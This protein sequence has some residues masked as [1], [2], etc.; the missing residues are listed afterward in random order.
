MHKHI[1]SFYNKDFKGIQFFPEEEVLDVQR[2]HVITL[3]IPLS[4]IVFFIFLTVGFVFS[5]FYFQEVQGT[6]YVVFLLPL[7]AAVLSML[8]MFA[9]YLFMRWFYQFYIITSKRLIHIHYFRIGGFHLDEVFYLQTK[10][11]EVERQP[12]NFFFD[13]LGIEDISVYFK[14]LER[15]IPFVFNAPPDSNKIEALLE[16][17]LLN[18]GSK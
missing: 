15:T 13:F 3:I 11:T 2:P 7:V 1:G 4:A 16:E 12:Q 14:N 17:H 5:L 9:I 6:V 10:P 8:S 18:G